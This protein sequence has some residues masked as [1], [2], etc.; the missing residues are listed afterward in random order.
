MLM[1]WISANIISLSKVIK[2]PQQ[3]V[4]ANDNDR[5]AKQGKGSQ[6]QDQG[7]GGGCNREENEMK[8]T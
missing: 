4:E 2:R 6:F 8:Q 1:F 7:G 3:S 5:L